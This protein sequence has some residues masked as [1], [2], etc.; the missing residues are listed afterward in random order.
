MVVDK[1]WMDISNRRLPRYEEG[2]K[3]FIEFAFSGCSANKLLRCPCRICKNNYFA[4]QISIMEHLMLNGIWKEY[5]VWDHHGESVSDSEDSDDNMEDHDDYG[6]REMVND[7]G[8]A[9]NNN[10]G[11][12]DGSSPCLQDDT[13]A[14]TGPTEEASKFYRL[15]EEAD[16]ELYPECSTFSTLSFIVQMMNIKCLYDLS[17]NAMDALFTLFWKVLPTKNKAPKSFNDAK[18]VMSDLGL[19]YK[20]IDA[21]PNDC[22]LYRGDYAKAESCPV[23]K[24]SRWKSDDQNNASKSRRRRVRNVAQKVLRYFPLI[25]RLKRM[26]M[27]SKTATNMRWHK[28]E[29]VDDGY[30][31]HPAD[32][33]EWKDFDKNFPSFAS[34]ARSVRL[35]LASDRF[36]PFG[37]M[38]TSYS[39]WPVVIVMYNLP[40]WMC[41]KDP[42]MI[43]SMLIPGPKAPGNDIDVYLQPLIDELIEL[44][45]GVE[46]YDAS[47]K[48]KF[49]L[50]AA[51]LWT[52]N[53][54]PALGNLSGMSTKGKY[55]CPSCHTDTCYQWLANGRKG[56]YMGHR[57]FLPAR[58]SWRNNTTFNGQRERRCAPKPLSGAE[59]LSQ[60]EKFTQVIFGKSDKKRKRSSTVYGVW[61][62]KSIFFQLPYWSKLT[63]RHN[64][65]VMHIEK[66]VG[67]SLASTLLGQEGKTKDNI[68]SRFDMEIMG[69]Q[70]K[71]HATPTDDGKF[72]FHNAP[73]TLFGPKRK[74]FCEFLTK[75]KVPYG[76]SAK[77]SNYVDAIN[78]KIS[79][80]KYCQMEMNELNKAQAYVLKN[81]EE[82]SPYTGIHKEYLR[83][84]STKNVDKRHEKE[85]FQWFKNHISTM[86]SKGD[87]SI[88]DELFD[89]ARGPDTGVTHFS[90]YMV[91]GWRFNTRDRD[92]L[93]QAQNSGVFVKGDEGTGNKDYFGVLTDIVELLYGT[94]KVVLFK[95]EWWDV[96]TT[97][98]VKEDKYGFIMINTTRRLSTDEPYVLA[99]QAEQVYYVNDTQDPKWYVV[100]KTKPRDY[101]DTPPTDEE[102]ATTKSSKSSPEA[103]QENEVIT[104][105]NPNTIEDDDTSILDTPQVEA[106][107]EGMPVAVEGNPI[108]HYEGDVQ[109]EDEQQESESDD[110]EG[111]EYMDSDDE[112]SESEE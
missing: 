71:L 101:F 49:T 64:L 12:F 111:G 15:L 84:Q 94:H 105:P 75:I 43:T 89:L 93:F 55:A 27:C 58:H 13:T 40:P 73:Y 109:D 47:M 18:K 96:H 28:E 68:N 81:C 11:S 53:D 62:K 61:K 99:S 37:H 21:C 19:D 86:Y 25:P 100:V 69:I 102:D 91:N 67:E 87:P 31:R 24:L 42:Y 22:I 70:P 48:R 23:C 35:G 95:C 6:L 60:Y 8:N 74:A 79:G 1:S 98:G 106:E 41:M 2:A 59:V 112:D 34:D 7:F 17:G 72:L 46:A 26:Y 88:S 20:R 36:N 97:R 108:L 92:A 90:S 45:G 85:F 52:I 3:K 110:S 4:D 44:W 32:S 56:C 77:V 83:T 103:C 38:S 63:L 65:D 16:N 54:F 107:A 9:V 78:V 82:A 80:M 51:L 57:R 50:K 5:R 29:L 66:N 10:L 39:I 14:S 76:Y 30:L 104:V 33:K